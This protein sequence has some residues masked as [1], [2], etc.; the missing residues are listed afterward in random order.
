MSAKE[1]EG[2][3][4]RETNEFGHVTHQE[5]EKGT[6]SAEELLRAQIFVQDTIAPKMSKKKIYRRSVKNQI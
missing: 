3:R 5:E 4:S 6:V 2:R 1:E